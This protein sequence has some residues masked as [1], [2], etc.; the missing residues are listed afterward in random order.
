MS[1][2]CTSSG[3]AAR[4]RPSFGSGLAGVAATAAVLS[5][6]DLLVL[7]DRGRRTQGDGGDASQQET[8]YAISTFSVSPFG[9]TSQVWMPLL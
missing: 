2:A 7:R 6:A 3:M 4:P 1:Q 8:A 5:R 9:R